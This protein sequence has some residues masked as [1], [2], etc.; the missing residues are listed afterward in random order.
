MGA[1]GR[2]GRRAGRR[3]GK[4]TGT[5]AAHGSRTSEGRLLTLCLLSPSVVILGFGLHRGSSVQQDVSCLLLMHRCKVFDVHYGLKATRAV[6]TLRRCH[7][8]PHLRF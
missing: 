4:V 1:E 3:A 8:L 6:C 5:E 2:G 7:M